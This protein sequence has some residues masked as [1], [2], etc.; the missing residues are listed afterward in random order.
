MF[1]DIVNKNIWK[2]RKI[3]I[4]R[5]SVIDFVKIG[6]QRQELL[7]STLLPHHS[8]WLAFFDK[9]LALFDYL[10]P[11]SLHRTQ[12]NSKSINSTSSYNSPSIPN[13]WFFWN[14]YLI[15]LIIFCL[16]FVH[17][18]SIARFIHMWIW[19]G[20]SKIFKNCVL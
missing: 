8:Q 18:W 1:P 14:L 15:L 4:T 10:N 6:M 20:N 12:C 11:S 7:P 19:Y 13:F 16:N 2:L 17:M 9:F 3:W 5:N